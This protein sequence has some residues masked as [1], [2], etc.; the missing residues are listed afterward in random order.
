MQAKS[1]EKFPDS[2]I[3]RAVDTSPGAGRGWM[4]AA[5]LAPRGGQGMQLRA[6]RLGRVPGGSSHLAQAPGSSGDIAVGQS[7]RPAQ[8]PAHSDG[9]TDTEGGCGCTDTDATTS[10]APWEP[11]HDPGKCEAKG[12]LPQYMFPGTTTEVRGTPLQGH[13]LAPSCSCAARTS[14]QALGSRGV[15]GSI[16][17]GTG[18]G[19]MA[20]PLELWDAS[21]QCSAVSFP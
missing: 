1:P 15:S 8:V 9:D 10:P 3:E 13:S 5:E 7:P 18:N 19:P 11:F 4:R 21:P 16:P 17:E 20:P 12:D 14:S 6:A 2:E